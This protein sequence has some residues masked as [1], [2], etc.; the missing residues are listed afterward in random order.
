MLI[1]VFKVIIRIKMS[2]NNLQFQEPLNQDANMFR[3]V[4]VK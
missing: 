2:T 4:G 1:I 3:V